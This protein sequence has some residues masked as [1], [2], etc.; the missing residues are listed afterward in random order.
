M[1][2]KYT[3][4]IMSQPMTIDEKSNPRSDES[5]QNNNLLEQVIKKFNA[6]ANLQYEL[7]VKNLEI[8][9]LKKQLQ[10]KNSQV[11]NT[12]SQVQKDEP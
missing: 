11:K 1:V 5:K 10:N 8:N 12:D 6:V 4:E 7:T 3:Q 2:Y 9:R